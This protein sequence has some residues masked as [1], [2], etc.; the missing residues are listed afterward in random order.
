MEEKT[1]NFIEKSRIISLN[2]LETC[3]VLRYNIG[4]YSLYFIRMEHTRKIM[5]KQAYTFRL[6]TP[7]HIL[8][9]SKLSKRKTE[10][11]FITTW[12]TQLWGWYTL[13]KV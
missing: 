1:H 11:T 6:S 12:G 2:T 10:K 9:M 8:M 3:G 4:I 5:K 13:G 7:E